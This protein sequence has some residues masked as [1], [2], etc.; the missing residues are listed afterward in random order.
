LFTSKKERDRPYLLDCGNEPDV[1]SFPSEKFFIFLNRQDRKF[2]LGIG[3]LC[4]LLLGG[5]DYLSGEIIALSIIYLIPVS[6]TAWFG[7]RKAGI[8]V[9]FLSAATWMTANYHAGAAAYESLALKFWNSAT[10]FGFFAVVSVILDK[11]RRTLDQERELSRT[12]YLTG[13]VNSRAFSEIAKAEI[14]RMRRYGRPFTVAYLDLDNFKEVNDK[15]G[16]SFGN[17]LLR[18]VTANMTRNIRTTDVVARI[19]GDEFVILFP[20]TGSDVAREVLPKFRERLLTSM[21]ELGWPITFSVGVLT[22]DTSPA[23]LDEVIGQ[24][25][26]L[27]L[28]VKRMGKNAICYAEYGKL[29]KST[30]SAGDA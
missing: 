16:H 6:F 8:T 15:Y 3:V 9:S 14:L 17:E 30:C 24:A 4:T 27:M 19:G 21:R 7:G 22:C 20:E 10:A 1:K 26:G 12:D 5:L 2:H 23:S 25:D 29:R 11:L 18:S 13:A 28:N